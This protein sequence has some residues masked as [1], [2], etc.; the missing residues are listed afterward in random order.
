MCWCKVIPQGTHWSESVHRGIIRLK[1]ISLHK[2]GLKVGNQ[3]DWNHETRLRP[4]RR[5]TSGL[6]AST[7]SLTFGISNVMSSFYP[8]YL[9]ICIWHLTWSQGPWPLTFGRQILI[10]SSVIH[11]EHLYWIWRLSHSIFMRYGIHKKWDLHLW[12]L[13]TKIS[14]PLSLSE[15]LD[16]I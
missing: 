9:H 2:L 3:T 14:S 5:T 4:R 15:H 13:A 1:Q 7:T 6:S 8:L 11:T 10:S 12:P 16:Q